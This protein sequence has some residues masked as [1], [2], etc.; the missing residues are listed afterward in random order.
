MLL[1]EAAMELARHWPDQGE[2]PTRWRTRAAAADLKWLA[3]HLKAVA[4]E[5]EQSSLAPGEAAI[6]ELAGRVAGEVERLAE[7]L[8]EAVGK[9]PGI[10]EG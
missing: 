8:K 9:P 10:E 6:S 5:R 4:R 3:G 1:Y 7:T 2:A